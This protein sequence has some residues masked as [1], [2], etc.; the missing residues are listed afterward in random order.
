M[1][2]T[3]GSIL[4]CMTISLNLLAQNTIKGIV[5]IAHSE[6]PLQGVSIQIKSENKSILTQKDGSFHFNDLSNG[7]F[8]I[9]LKKEGYETQSYP[10]SLFGKTID[11]G[12]IFIYE[13]VFYE[14]QDQ[15]IITITDDELNDDS[16]IADNISGLLQASK[17]TYLRTAAF[18]FSAA[19]F[20][21]RGLDSDNA[22][23]LINGVEM[24]KLSTGRP[25]WGNWGGLNDVLRNQEFTNGLTPSTYAF[26]GILGS[27]NINTR[28]SK[29][30]KGIRA[31]YT[32]SN[33]SYRHRAMATYSSGVL[34]NDW[35]FSVSG[36]K[37]IGDEGFVDGT[38]YNATSI[39]ASVEKI[40]NDKHSFNLTGVFASNKRGT[41]SSNTQ[42]VIDL[43]GIKYNANWG[44]QNGKIRNASIKNIEEPFLILSH[45][46]TINNKTSLNINTS[47]QFG[48]TGRSRIDY[49][50]GTNPI[51]TSHRNLPSFWLAKN[52]IVQAYEAEQNF[53][54]NGQLNWN[55]LYDANINNSEQGINA[56]YV[57]YEDRVDDRTLNINAIFNTEINDHISIDSKI[58]YTNLN[59]EN[60]A[61]V[62]DNLG[63]TTGYLD[64]NGFAKLGTLERQND[65][66]NPNR[67]VSIGDRFKYNY[68]ISS[69]VINGFAQAQ[70]KYNKIDFYI[71]SELSKTSYQREGLY[72]NGALPS[73]HSFNSLGKSPLLDFMSF[74]AKGGVTYKITGRHLVDFNAGYVTKAPTIRNSFTQVRDSNFTTDFLTNEKTLS[75]DASY[76]VRSPIFTSRLTGYY[77]TIE[78]SI[79]TSFF[80]SQGLQTEGFSQE[81]VTGV[82]KSHLGVELGF[83]IKVT[84]ALHIK[85]AGNFGE[86]FYTNNP[87]NV[88]LVQKGISTQKLE[89]IN[90]GEPSLKN[91]RLNSGPQKTASLGLEYRDP[92]YWWVSLTG[93]YFDDSYIGISSILRTSRFF[94]DNDDLPITDYDPEEAKRLLTQQE[95]GGYFVANVIGGK[96]W[97]INK[98]N[99]YI[100][101]TLGVSNI[102]NQQ[103]KTGGFEQSRTGD[104]RSLK[105]DFNNS[106]RVFGPR[107]W[108]GRGTNYFF[109]VYFRF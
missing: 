87:K 90:F 1:K 80:F 61:S 27:T 89:K 40:I 56:A 106:K 41:G 44:Y 53:I 107:F 85:G 28:A 39:F 13:E 45:Y 32:S 91:Y 24:N 60:F 62:L 30:R 66:L 43:K 69:E 46:W 42:E 73:N 71:A 101:F 55:S 75:F 26:G 78:D 8:I 81:I 21:I 88:Q 20:K 6:K 94:T 72:Q 68:T 100:G 102:L 36:S 10:V 3:I 99:K 67:E 18:E 58:Q 109:N 105:E 19:F 82:N 64:V 35:A 98:T 33:R 2:K 74:G 54:N 57:L 76:I 65:L 14:E 104:F 34:K 103:F 79:N 47:Y 23:L 84:P 96:S 37:R 77:I 70:F 93:N 92:D 16:N 7:N 59:S 86:Y 52:D 95:F 9:V 97:K 15:S 108:N 31:S 50:G 38:S 22:K 51:P 25:E 48:K 49:N 63:S 5:K 11:L 17:D 83:K 29:Y 12:I 4:F